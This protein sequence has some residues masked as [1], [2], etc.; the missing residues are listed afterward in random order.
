MMVALVDEIQSRRVQENDGGGFGWAAIIIVATAL[1]I[2]SMKKSG[3]K[4]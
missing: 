3:D 2:L 4:V 1:D